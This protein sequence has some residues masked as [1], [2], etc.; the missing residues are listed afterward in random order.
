MAKISKK[1]I[2]IVVPLYNEEASVPAFNTA[3]LKQLK[4]LPNYRFEIVYVND[5][6]IDKTA[7]LIKNFVSQNKDIKLLELSRNF[8][9]ESALT[10]GIT[11]AKGN[12]IITMDGDL[13]HPVN[14][15]PKFINKWESGSVVVVGVRQKSKSDSTIKKGGS[16]IFY[17]TF[18]AFGDQ[19]IVPGSTDFRLIDSSVQIEFIKLKESGRMTRSLIDW[20]GFNPSYVSFVADDRAA[21][22][23]SYKLSKLIKLAM[24]SFVSSSPAP[25]FLFGIIGFFITTASLLLGVFILVEQLLFGDPWN[26]QFTGTAMLAILILFLVGLILMSQGII[27]VYLSHIHTQSKQRPL[28]VIDYNNSKGIDKN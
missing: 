28:Y 8:G 7:T 12:A 19:T 10:A 18:N 1:L 20:L 13:Q 24:D 5:G 4:L 23:A 16:R 22:H 6:S 25:L 3:L 26:L 21:G 17:K 11:L 9:K 2:S 27:S 15:I 14:M